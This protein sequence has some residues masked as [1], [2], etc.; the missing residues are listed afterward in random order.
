MLVS[1]LNDTPKLCLGRLR[2]QD[3]YLTSI[4]HDL[5]RRAEHAASAATEA[6]WG[7]LLCVMMA[8]DSPCCA[9]P[10]A[11]SLEAQEAVELKLEKQPH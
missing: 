1:G 3:N 4:Y 5:Q 7:F 11:V 9:P 6:S 2:I 8:C 10:T